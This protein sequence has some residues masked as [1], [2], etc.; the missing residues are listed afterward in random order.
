MEIW[1][2]MKRIREAFQRAAESPRVRKLK[3]ELAAAQAKIENL[4]VELAHAKE[5]ATTD[6]LTGIANRRAF[7]EALHNQINIISHQEP[8]CSEPVIV[9]LLDVDK[10]KYINDQYGHEYGDILLKT[11]IDRLKEHLRQSD[12]LARIGGD[13]F[14]ILPYGAKSPKEFL[15]RL[16]KILSEP[17]L[18]MQL[19]DDSTFKIT[20]S[21]GAAAY[22]HPSQ[23]QHL[24]QED[25]V[26]I[27]DALIKKADT[28]MYQHKQAKNPQLSQNPGG[29]EC[30]MAG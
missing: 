18:T 10:L 14:T 22:N 6:E 4:E 30:R 21:V 20:V 9:A 29:P 5:Q 16:N 26:H 27:A 13:E 19:P 8:V 15:D 25:I 7:H 17:P 12:L 23:E 28:E 24:T 2:S 1:S 11:L 3:D